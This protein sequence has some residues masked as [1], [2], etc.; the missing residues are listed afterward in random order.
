MTWS[1]K[2]D[3]IKFSE[4]CTNKDRKQVEHVIFLT[5]LPKLCFYREK[6]YIISIYLYYPSYLF[7]AN[8]WWNGKPQN[9]ELK[10]TSEI[11]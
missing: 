1:V 10:E 5:G 7:A 8:A 4:S 2:K 11:I 3:W 9:S 6:D